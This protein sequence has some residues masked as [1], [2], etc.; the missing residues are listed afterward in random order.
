MTLS[1]AGRGVNV[2]VSLQ[3]DALP[4]GFV[5]AN[6]SDLSP[7]ALEITI[8]KILTRPPFFFIRGKVQTH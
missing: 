7:L 6:S 5:K 3:L 1:G 8:S 4:H 2:P